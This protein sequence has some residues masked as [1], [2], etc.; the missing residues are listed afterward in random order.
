MSSQPRQNSAPKLV[1][2][3]KGNSHPFQERV[4]YL[5]EPQKVG[6]S[7]GRIKPATN[8]L[9]FDCKVLSRNHGIVWYEHNQ[10]KQKLIYLCKHDVFILF[11]KNFV[12]KWWRRCIE[13]SKIGQ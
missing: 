7:V 13:G 5:T 10:V 1:F 12:N 11:V 9:I 4:L 6:R 2:A 3:S 8:N